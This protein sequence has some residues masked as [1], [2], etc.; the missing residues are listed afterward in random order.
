[1]YIGSRWNTLSVIYMIFMMSIFAG[2]LFAWLSY[3][4][5]WGITPGLY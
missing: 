1:M 4:R 5:L 3:G 2:G